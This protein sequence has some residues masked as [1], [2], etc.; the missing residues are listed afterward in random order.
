MNSNSTLRRYTTGLP[1]LDRRLDGGIP[2]GTLLS[3]VAP[4][5][6]QSELLL[7]QLVQT[8]Q[9]LFVSTHRPPVEVKAWAESGSGQ[10]VDLS[11]AH[12]TVSTLLD[13]PSSIRPLP[14]ESLVILDRIT[15]LEDHARETYLAFLNSL[16]EELRETDSVGVVHC[17]TNDRASSH[18]D[19]TLSRS[20]QV[21]KLELLFSSREIKNRLF[22][23]KSR[24]SRTLR[25][26]IDLLLTDQVQVDTSRRI[27]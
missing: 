16:K 17:P 6:S 23:T 7:K 9:T 4:P 25:E 1:F 19:L 24:Y 22:V 11:V 18:R 13:D 15:A 5:E 10:P 8:R 26:P 27:A 12:P 21:W 3:I 14:A 20:D 2:S